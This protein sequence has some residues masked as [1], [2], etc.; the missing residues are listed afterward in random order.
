MTLVVRANTIVLVWRFKDFRF[1]PNHFCNWL[2]LGYVAAAVVSWNCFTFCAGLFYDNFPLRLRTAS[3][4]EAMSLSLIYLFNFLLLLLSVSLCFCYSAS[5]C[6]IIFIFWIIF[7][8]LFSG[9]ST[10]V[11][12]S[13]ILAFLFLFLKFSKLNHFKVNCGAHFILARA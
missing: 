3:N 7:T 11:H 1:Q 8:P 5:T 12:I 9:P 6:D 4:L 10:P 2:W 13:T